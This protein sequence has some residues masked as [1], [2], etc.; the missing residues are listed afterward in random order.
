MTKTT[1][2]RT[3]TQSEVDELKK[4]IISLESDIKTAEMIIEDN[5]KDFEQLRQELKYDFRDN[6]SQDGLLLFNT[7]NYLFNK[8]DKYFAKYIKEDSK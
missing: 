1:K 7:L 6:D 4:K 3:H 2:E 5:K 8:L